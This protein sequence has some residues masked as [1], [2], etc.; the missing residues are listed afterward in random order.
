MFEIV[1]A[2]ANPSLCLDKWHEPLSGIAGQEKAVLD[3]VAKLS[4]DFAAA[5][6]NTATLRRAL[7]ESACWVELQSNAPIAL[8]L[9]RATGFENASI[10]MHPTYAVPYLPATGLKG[11]ARHYAESCLGIA[12]NDVQRIF[13]THGL[14]AADG[15]SAGSVR[16]FDAMPADEATCRGLQ[17]D[18]VNSHHGEYYM[19]K[20]DHYEDTE[21][22]VPVFFLSLRKGAKFWFCI[23]ESK[24]AKKGDGELAMRWLRGGLALLG[25]G[26][27][28][29]AGYGR[30]GMIADKPERRQLQ[31]LNLELRSPAFLAGAMQGSGDCELRA[32]VLRGVLRWWW[33]ACFG[34]VLGVKDLRSLEATIWG[35]ASK[36]GAIAIWVG[37]EQ[38]GSKP[39]RWSP[40]AVKRDSANRAYLAYGMAER[41]KPVR[42]YMP[43]GSKWPIQVMTR[44]TKHGESV[45]GP[46][47]VM[48]HFQLALYWAMQ[49]GGLGA[50]SRKGFGTF[51]VDISI[52][53]LKDVVRWI[54]G[55]KNEAGLPR[56]F[57]PVLLRAAQSS[58]VDVAASD[59]LEAIDKLAAAYKKL[60]KKTPD[61]G[62]PRTGLRNALSR[63][64]SPLHMT[65]RKVTVPKGELSKYRIRITTLATPAINQAAIQSKTPEKLPPLQGQLELEQILKAMAAK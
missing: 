56:Q 13:G 33:R 25:V 64:A 10:A 1:P 63:C 39:T 22:P 4:G 15:S 38:T 48:R 35:S 46:E 52:G 14:D 51:R 17:V 53:D 58:N 60:N 45:I 47:E 12:K 32:P 43:E 44:E 11:L 21:N 61:Y 41:N 3:G 59:S 65:V 30:F 2:N 40:P 9:A 34:H 50:K 62:L 5:H 27:K 16:F 7:G 28:T 19:G 24:R 23:A 42:Y 57:G 49:F 55:Y 8:H 18:I 6:R 37:Q 26:A 36:E 54:G 29:N 31:E 20:A